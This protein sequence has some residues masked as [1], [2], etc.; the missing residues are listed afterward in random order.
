MPYWRWTV[1][2]LAQVALLVECVAGAHAETLSVSSE[3]GSD[4]SLPPLEPGAFTY[5]VIPDTQLYHGKDSG[6]KGAGGERPAS[7]PAFES[8][9]DWIVANAEKERIFFVSHVGD[10]IDKR[11]DAQW[12]FASRLMKRME[13]VVPYAIS[14][15]NHDIGKFDMSWFNAYFPRSRFEG[16]PWYAGAFEG[17]LGGEDG[18]LPVSGGN[19]NSCQLAEAD[20]NKFVFFHLECNAPAPVLEWVG[21]MLDRYSD[22]RGIVCT[23]MFVGY[24]TRQIDFERRKIPVDDPKPDDW[25]GISDWAKC[26]GRYGVTPESAWRDYLSKHRN[27]ILVV[28]GDQS[29]AISA[30]E[31]R[32][33]VHGNLV[34]FTLQDYPRRS[35]KDDWLRLYR[36]RKDMSAIDVLTYS[37]QRDAICQK[38][39]FRRGREW[40]EFTLPLA[41]ARTLSIVSPGEGEVVSQ[42]Y[43]VQRTYALESRSEREKYFDGG[44]AAKRLKGEGSAPK[45]IVLEWTAGGDQARVSLRRLP[46]GKVFL[47]TTVPSNRIEVDSL[48]IGREWEVTV[49]SGSDKAVSRFRTEDLPPRLVRIEGVPNVRDIGGRRGLGGR[50]LKQ[51]LVYRS[52]GLNDNAPV[53]YYSNDEIMEFH[54]QGT[55]AQMG[56][57]GKALEEK[58]CRGK[59]LEACPEMNRLIK[60][61]KFAAGAR[62]LTESERRRVLC[63]YGFRTDIDLRRDWECFGM[64]GSPLGEEVRWLNVPY[65][66]Y[67]ET[68][69][70]ENRE[71]NRRVFGAFLKE[72][73]YPIVFHCIGGADRTGT[74]AMLLE[75][76]LG[77]TEDEIWSDYLATGFKGS[78]TDRRHR[79]RLFLPTMERLKRY[80]GT[81]LAE[82]AEAWFVQIGFSADDIAALRDRLLE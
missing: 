66:C 14:P 70:S 35:D 12:K 79:D 28:S 65:V 68:F 23:H 47:R 55:L 2:I 67:A 29:P 57:T 20:G 39:G 8:R 73:N 69:D 45:P 72:E 37:P 62:R 44:D 61:Q 77:V 4:L 30:R 54:R 9:I 11:K 5:C 18:T 40:H 33:G 49:S 75:A 31:S 1:S 48:E 56:R 25:F 22:R 59:P 42:L 58:L 51:G 76:L 7:N 13:G 15:G 32:R 6:E 71:S 43:P 3:R 10:I 50:R 52:A 19:V 74:V 60:R 80:P 27:L 81:T 26:H 63:R 53:E 82:K 17:C 41:P 78:V 24:K 46:D 34:H 64:T 16:F 21:E 38:A 36:F